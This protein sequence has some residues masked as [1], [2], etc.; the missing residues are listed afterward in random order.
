MGKEIQFVGDTISKQP[1]K[2]YEDILRIIADKYDVDIV[3]ASCHG[4]YETIPQEM[5][6]DK[7]YIFVNLLPKEFEGTK[8]VKLKG[9]KIN[10]EELLFSVK[11]DEK[12]PGNQGPCPQGD[13]LSF[14]KAPSRAIIIND[15]AEVPMAVILDGSLYIVNDFIHSRSKEDFK[16][17]S[18]EFEYILAKAIVA[19]LIDSVKGGLEEKSK[20]SLEAALR[21]QFTQRLEKEMVQL[22][23]A[24]DLIVQYEKGICDSTKKYASTMRIIDA[25][26]GNIEDVENALNKTW[27]SLDKMA[28]SVLY[29]NISYTKNGIKALTAP[30]IIKHDKKDYDLGKYEVT[31][32]YEGTCKIIGI[33]P[34]IEGRFDHPHIS[35]GNVCWGNFAGQIPKLIGS[36]EFDV[37]LDMI[38]TFLAHYD[39]GN[40]YKTIEHWPIKAKEVKK[41]VTEEQKLEVRA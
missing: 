27:K 23:A 41:E 32:S 11:E 39:T 28:H 9:F 5:S 24:N 19:G 3:L 36:S 7:L 31:L 6:F 13:S 20:R 37:A 34:K 10:G 17:G 1:Q 14:T 21:L 18:A 26:R 8:K 29:T 25:I 2:L 33:N 22:K 16:V 12:D 4:R 35:D 30:I 38:Y 15:E 40:P